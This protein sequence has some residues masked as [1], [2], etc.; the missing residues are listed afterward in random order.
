M[1]D[2]IRF[3]D[4]G[5]YDIRL[6]YVRIPEWIDKMGLKGYPVARQARWSPELL[7]YTDLGIFPTCMEKTQAGLVIQDGK[8]REMMHTHFPQR[9]YPNFDAIPPILIE[10][11][12]FIENRY[13][14]K[15]SSPYGNPAIEWKRQAKA[16]GDV[17]YSFIDKNHHV[18]GGSTLATQ[19][20]KFRHSPGGITT[21]TMEKFRQ[22]VSASFRAYLAGEQTLDTRKRI[23]LDYINAIPLAAIR[24][25]GEVN[26]LGDGL[27]AW[28]GMEFDTVNR[29]LMEISRNDLKS[30][31]L[32][33]AGAVLKSALSLFLS[34]R[35]PSDYLIVNRQAL[36]DLT[37]SHLRLMAQDGIIPPALR[38]AALD[39]RLKFQQ[40]ASI[41]YPV[42]PA[43]RKAANL[44]RSRL[45]T[46]LEFGRQYDL[47]RV[48]LTVRTTLDLD[49]QRRVTE[50]LNSLKDP[51]IVQKAGIKAPFLLETGDPSR[52]IYSFSLYEHTPNGNMLR[53]QTNNF[54]GQ[55][56][57]D[58]QTKLDLGSSAKLRT[59]VHYLEIIQEL[60]YKYAG[61]K[62]PDL[63]KLAE[64]S[65]PDPLTR[66]AIEYLFNTPDRELTVMLN[67][68][69]DRMYS[70]SPNERFFTGG[71][72]HTFANFNREDNSRVMSVRE[73]L[74]N[75]IN[76][77]FIRIMRDISSYHVFQRYGVTPRSLEKIDASRRKELLTVFADREG[78][79]FVKRFFNKY[80]SKNDGDA[81]HLLFAAIRP[82]PWRLAAAF[83]YV[84]PSAPVEDFARFFQEYLP[85]S[86]LTEP[87]VN[88][89]YNDYSPDNFSL[90]DIGYITRTHPLELWVVRYMLDSPGVE[91]P[92]IIKESEDERQEVYQWLLKTK[93]LARQNQRIRTIIE[94]E[95]F[96]DIHQAWKRLGYPFDYLVPSY[97][98]AIG[99]SAD[100]PGALVEL[101]GIIQNNGMRYPLNRIE[102]F[103]FGKDTP[104]ETLLALASPSGEQVLAPEVS[105]VVRQAILGVVEDGTAR[106]LKD[107]VR[108]SDGTYLPIGGKTGTGDHR[109]K[110]F[111]PGGIIIN[112][113]VMNRAAT[114][115]FI[116]GDTY[117]GVISAFVPGSEAENYSF[118][119]SLPVHILKMLL[120]DL[121]PFLNLSEGSIE[122]GSK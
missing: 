73:A 105:A 98:T 101:A 36:E 31:E 121:V 119:S 5:P 114:F 34:Q 102:S 65:S 22:I 94:L 53:V 25:F 33:A 113:K 111:G 54:E 93:S 97:A 64:D 83:R 115:V 106:R 55:F 87:F 4:D 51:A 103:H 60:F 6:G 56:N 112:S 82:T 15:P 104:Y 71:G 41:S 24:G 92:E 7:K 19:T 95:A 28:Y 116:M 49:L 90:A 107:A 17:A 12:L 16:L 77:I 84:N 48:D 52:V 58:E 68:A 38:D 86:K 13:L 66:W 10:M 46:N 80:M 39:A 120:P 14:L 70:A 30:E 61:M 74:K 42:E 72:L 32:D 2:G 109:Y 8:N 96:Q 9:V 100:R 3:P 89:L 26:S 69:M 20:E 35:R 27:W 67:A 117:F 75:S 85:D 122:S 44:I 37:D 99:S 29:M 11:L 21:G 23:V 62:V 81:R 40:E 88:S 76:L 59:L 78:I 79:L 45:M 118:S 91:L 47:D 43:Y 50:T 57:I 1:S 18:A 63:E 108:L 110:T